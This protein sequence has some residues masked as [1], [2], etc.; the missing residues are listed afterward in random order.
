[1]FFKTPVMASD[2]GFRRLWDLLKAVPETVD[3]VREGHWVYFQLM[4]P[5]RSN[6]AKERERHHPKLVQFEKESIKILTS[7]PGHKIKAIDFRKFFWRHFKRQFEATDYGY[8]KMKRMLVLLPHIVK[9]EDTKPQYTIT[10]L[11]QESTKEDEEQEHL[12][13]VCMDLEPEVALVPCSHNDLCRSC[14]EKIYQKDRRCPIDRT[15]ITGIIPLSRA[16]DV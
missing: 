9:I 8:P 3:V 10:L 13:I 14:A 12:C 2:Y 5:I 11:P 1:M 7:M 16:G 6:A 4:E 15:E